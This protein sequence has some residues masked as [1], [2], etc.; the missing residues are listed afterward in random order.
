MATVRRWIGKFSSMA[1]SLCPACVAGQGSPTP[2][3]HAGRR[4]GIRSGAGAVAVLEVVGAAGLVGAGA[5]GGGQGGLVLGRQRIHRLS[6]EHLLLGGDALGATP[7]QEADE[8]VQEGRH[9]VLE[10]DDV[11]EV[12]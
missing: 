11:D 1:V 2:T 4:H 9:A 12:D 3:V 10:A 8:P 7:A 6:T 5:G